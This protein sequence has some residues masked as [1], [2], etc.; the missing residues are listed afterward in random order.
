[1]TSPFEFTF[2]IT[3]EDIMGQVLQ[4][5][6]TQIGGITAL[7]TIIDPL[8]GFLEFNKDEINTNFAWILDGQFRIKA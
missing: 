8:W 4:T 5:S 2:R 3:C 1:M 6:R 7:H